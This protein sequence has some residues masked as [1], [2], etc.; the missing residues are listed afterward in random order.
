MTRQKAK[1]PELIALWGHMTNELVVGIT[2]A[3]GWEVIGN[4][5]AKGMYAREG[6]PEEWA[7]KLMKV[8]LVLRKN[9][10]ADYTH[11]ATH[12]LVPPRYRELRAI[13][14]PATEQGPGEQPELFEVAP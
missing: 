11:L 8:F 1:N 7:A 5:N 3:I 10:D 6:C 13:E 9:P 2:R 14:R 4:A 12:E